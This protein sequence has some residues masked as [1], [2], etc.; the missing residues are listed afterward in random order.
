MGTIGPT[1]LEGKI[2]HGPL[3]FGAD[4]THGSSFWTAELA[5]RVYRRLRTLFC[6]VFLLSFLL[7][8]FLSLFLSVLP[9]HFSFPF[10]IPSSLSSF[11]LFTSFRSLFPSPSYS[12]LLSFSFSFLSLFFIAVHRHSQLYLP[13]ISSPPIPS[14][15][16]FLPFTSLSC[17]LYF[18]YIFSSCFPIS[19][20]NFLPF[21]SFFPSVCCPTSPSDLPFLL[22]HC[23]FPPISSRPSYSFSFLQSLLSSC[24]RSISASSFMLFALF[25]LCSVLKVPTIYLVVFLPSS[26]IA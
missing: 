2:H 24:S 3:H 8:S 4:P 17:A 9:S 6:F 19:S 21:L 16:S 11:S 25:L 1:A 5:P 18:L 12:Y 23:F 13:P 15:L 7:S 26:P 20:Y 14:F 22:F 10:P